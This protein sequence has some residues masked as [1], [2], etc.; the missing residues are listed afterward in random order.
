ML[1][2]KDYIKVARILK[3]RCYDKV[4]LN[5]DDLI[6]D[7]CEWFTADNPNFDKEKFKEAILKE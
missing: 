2:K 5:R 3:S 7:F 4:N 1:T 6:N